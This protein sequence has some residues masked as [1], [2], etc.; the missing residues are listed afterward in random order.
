M[1]FVRDLAKE[2]LVGVAPGLIFGEGGEGN[3]RLS[4][5]AST[6]DLEESMRRIQAYMAK[7]YKHNREAQLCWVFLDNSM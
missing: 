3:I 6:E 4:Y 5:A 1:A 2:A 7:N